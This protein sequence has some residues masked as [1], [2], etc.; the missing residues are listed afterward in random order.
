[1]V[2]HIVMWNIQ[3]G[4]DKEEI[5]LKLKDK[6]EGLVREIPFLKK[7]ELG[8][9]YNESETAHD[10]ILYSEFDSKDDLSA[11]IVHPK[12]KEVGSFVRS[13]VCDRVDVDYEIK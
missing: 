8:R 6:L 10:V 11:Y 2:K 3:E 9:A 4:L 12:H 5:Y 7:I 13:V 1:M